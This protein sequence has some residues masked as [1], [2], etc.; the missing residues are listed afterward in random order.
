[1]APFLQQEIWNLIKSAF[2]EVKVC[3]TSTIN[4]VDLTLH[5]FLQ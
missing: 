3:K 5:R 1:L 4:L 2:H